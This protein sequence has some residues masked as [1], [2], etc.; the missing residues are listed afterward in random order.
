MLIATFKASTHWP[1]KTITWAAGRFTREGHGEILA[2]DVLSYDRQGYLSWA[3][4][5]LRDW[6]GSL[7]IGDPYLGGIVAYILPPVDRGYVAGETHGLIAAAADQTPATSGIQWATAPYW[8]TSVPGALGTAF[9]TGAANTDA[10]IAQNGAGTSYAAGLAR[11]YTGGGYSDW[12][13]PCRH[14]LMKLC[15]NRVAI[16]GLHIEPVDA[17]RYWSS[18]QYAVNAGNAWHQGFDVGLQ[19]GGNDKGSAFRVRAV[20]AF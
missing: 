18:S 14:E 19:S 16:G 6:V 3:N 12:F 11:A 15:L 2:V 7:A 9:G 13:L 20:R 5:G 8:S 1:G 4:E 10:I 17:P